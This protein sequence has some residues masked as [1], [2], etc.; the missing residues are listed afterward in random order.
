M[1]FE[2]HGRKEL[3]EALLKLPK[4]LVANGGGPV[5]TALMAATKPVL[6]T[7]KS[8]I[9][10]RDEIPNKGQLAR[11]I[12]RRRST[13]SGHGTE[14]IQV[15]IRKG[16]SRKDP[17]GAYYA[18]FVEFGA[19][20]LAPTHWFRDSLKS[21]VQNSTDIFRRRLAGSIARIAKKI[22]DENL[23]QVATR[24]KNL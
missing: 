18:P 21:N 11:A 23:R 9:P 3:Q 10:N 14:G 2:V 15:F 16:K 17:S 6:D 22:G 1:R 8:T 24:V 7:A 5:K 20:G 12:G 4:E 19:R 13:K